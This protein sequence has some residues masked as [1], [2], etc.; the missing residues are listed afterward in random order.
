MI[1]ELYIKNF[2][3]IEEVHCQFDEGMTVLTGE[4]GAGKSI[5]IDAVGLLVGERASLD[6]IRYGTDKAIIQGIFKIEDSQTQERLL[7]LGLSLEDELLLVQRE[8][9]QNG[10]SVCRINGQLATLSLL[11]QVGQGIIDIHGQ[12]EHFLLLD[13]QKHLGLLDSYIQEEISSLKETYSGAYAD[14]QKVKGDLKALLTDEKKDVQRM[15]ML[16]FQLKE[17]DEA[18]LVIGEE[19]ALIEERNH[20]THYQKI[21]QA[22]M[23]SINALEAEDVSAIDLVGS[24]SNE[25]GSIANLDKVYLDLSQQVSDAYYQLQDAI[26][27]ISNILES[28]TYDEERLNQIEERLNVYYQLKRK[29]GSH[30]EEIL[31]FADKARQ[32]LDAIENKEEHI[33]KLEKQVAQA[34][35]K[36]SQ[37]AMK[38]STLRKKAAKALTAEV[39]TQLK[40]LYMEKVQFAVNFQE[41]AE[42][43]DQG[44][45]SLEFY[46][47]TNLGEPLKPLSKIASGGELSRFTLALKAIF[48]KEQAISTVIFDEVD[49]GVSGRVAQAIAEKM[50]YISEFAQVLCITHLPQVASMANHH[51]RIEKVE[52]NQR[53]QT[54]LLELEESMRSQ[55]IARMLAGSQITDLTLQHAKEL[56]SDAKLIQ[57]RHKK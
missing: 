16:H 8:L 30:T 23:N 42:L 19:E 32:E 38:L 21:Q 41:L 1:Q 26:S 6:M 11:K 31:A 35:G 50:Q 4:T 5:I 44:M 46:A 45:D 20:F 25:L 33:E 39:E 40:D 53:T 56:L 18:A 29:Y 36:V 47:A 15:D 13:P 55:E 57:E 37:L 10:K 9:L 7:D 27:S 3:I 54:K 52:S 28:S 43:N 12:N 17:I 51:F 34:Q 22:L 48:V 49:S 14:Y 2:A 24:A